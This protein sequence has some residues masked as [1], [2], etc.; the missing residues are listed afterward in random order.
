M[1]NADR[2]LA[3][4][5]IRAAVERSLSK[6]RRNKVKGHADVRL[7]NIFMSLQHISSTY[8]NIVDRKYQSAWP[9]GLRR[10]T[11][12][13]MERSAQVRT[14]PLTFLHHLNQNRKV[15]ILKKNQVIQKQKC[16]RRKVSKTCILFRF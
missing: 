1:W 8:K 11:Q 16:K 7:T 6:K 14:L 5:D 9:S 13:R 12:V 10:A 15:D 3:Q 4:S 2:P